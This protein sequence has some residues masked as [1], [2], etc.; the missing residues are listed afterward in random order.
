MFRALFCIT[1]VGLSTVARACGHGC[2]GHHWESTVHSGEMLTQFLL[3]LGVIVGIIAW[4]VIL[5]LRR[6]RR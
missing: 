1:F 4:Q 6:A 5:Q 3:M 2:T